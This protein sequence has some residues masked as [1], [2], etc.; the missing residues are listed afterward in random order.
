VIILIKI[1]SRNV[2]LAKTDMAVSK[3]LSSNDKEESIIA[4]FFD[5]FLTKRD[6]VL[7]GKDIA[8]FRREHK[9]AKSTMH[10]ILHNLRQNEVI[11]F[12]RRYDRSL[13]KNNYYYY[14]N[15]KFFRML[16]KVRKSFH[17]MILIAGQN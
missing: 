13:Y 2:R 5:L 1:R 7:E 8:K 10:K 4:S 17:R 3:F 6:R 16:G 14:L 9:I 15:P 11:R 12:Q